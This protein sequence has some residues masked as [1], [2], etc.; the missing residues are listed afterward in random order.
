LTIYG[1]IP[2]LWFSRKVLDAA[3][4]GIGVHGKP[5]FLGFSP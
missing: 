5:E 3:G 1:L 2:D 4:G